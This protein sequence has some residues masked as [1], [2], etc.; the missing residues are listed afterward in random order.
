MDK[1]LM[2]DNQK[3]MRALRAK[4][5]ERNSDLATIIDKSGVTVEY[6]KD[7]DYLYIIIGE[8]RPGMAVSMGEATVIV[9]PDTLEILAIDVP[10]Y[11]EKMREHHFRG[12]WSY[13]VKRL[14]DGA[15]NLPREGEAEEI[16]IHLTKDLATSL[17]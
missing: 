6:N 2:L 15:T 12:A 1:R 11:F 14:G 9:D 17:R 4:V 8:P 13:F 3:K 16:G 10:F 5:M 7:E